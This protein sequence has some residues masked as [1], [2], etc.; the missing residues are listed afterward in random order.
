MCVTENYELDVPQRIFGRYWR[1]LVRWKCGV[2]TA[3]GTIVYAA[4]P[5]RVPLEISSKVRKLET[6][7]TA[8]VYS[9]TQKRSYI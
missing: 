3:V 8:S 2:T 9:C 6:L 1:Y 5:V 7:H 4:V